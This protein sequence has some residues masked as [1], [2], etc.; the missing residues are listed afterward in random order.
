[1]ESKK[2]ERETI[3]GLSPEQVQVYDAIESGKC[4]F[5]TGA[6]GTGKSYLLNMIRT[7]LATD[8]FYFTAMTG[9]AAV[10]IGGCTLHSFA[11]IGLGDANDL[12]EVAS[13]WPKVVK[14]WKTVQT[15]LIDEISMLDAEL[16]DKIEALARQF[17]NPY[18]FFGGIQVIFV[19]DFFQLP[20]VSKKTNYIPKRCYFIVKCGKTAMC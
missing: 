14:R 11:G 4:V 5:F 12:Y 8:R 20:P 18:L 10:A 1:M 13:K 6:G 9:L 7:H 15:L 16:F 19:G 17:R 2:R 3:K